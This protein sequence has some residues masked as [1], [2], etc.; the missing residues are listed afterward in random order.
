[1]ST[2][3]W[4]RSVKVGMES[5]LGGLPGPQTLPAWELCLQCP[6]ATLGVGTG[7]EPKV[8]RKTCPGHPHPASD[9]V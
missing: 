2:G 4:G 9:R 6:Q 7:L 1:M 5:R 8:N 3:T